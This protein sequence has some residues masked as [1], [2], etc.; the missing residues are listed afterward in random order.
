MAKLLSDISDE[1]AT[2]I[3]LERAIGRL[4]D[5]RKDLRDLQ[6]LALTHAVDSARHGSR[7]GAY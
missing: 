4:D 3:T 1:P 2:I 7:P 6:K 5:A